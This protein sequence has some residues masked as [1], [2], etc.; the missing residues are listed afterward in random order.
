MAAVGLG[1]LQIPV[2][3][4]AA[5]DPSQSDFGNYF[6]SA[7]VLARGGDLGQLYDRDTFAAAMG[8]AGLSGL[9][10]FIPHPPANA[11]WLVPRSQTKVTHA[12]PLN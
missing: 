2:L 6:T 3:L 8:E 5:A 11:L 10:S 9:G 7:F 12:L 4:G 1:V